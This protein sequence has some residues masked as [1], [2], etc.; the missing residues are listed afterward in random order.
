MTDTS[1]RFHG[2]FPKI[3]IRPTI[4]GRRKGVRES[5]EEQTMEMAKSVARLFAEN[6]RYPNGEPV[7]CV[8]ADTCIGGVA[9]SAAC[10]DKFL[11]EG[12]GVSTHGHALLVLWNRNDGYGC[13]NPQ[14]GMGLQRNGTSRRCLFGSCFVRL[15]AEGASCLRDLRKSCSGCWRYIYSR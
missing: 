2:K 6:L 14:S 8:I 5:L 9:E 7:E 1:Y 10:A 12:V 13:F 3:G 15:C 4:D 11:R